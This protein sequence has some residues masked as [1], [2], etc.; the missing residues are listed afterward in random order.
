MGHRHYLATCGETS[1]WKH[2]WREVFLSIKTFELFVRVCVCLS[3]CELTLTLW[4]LCASVSLC[5]CVCRGHVYKESSTRCHTQIY[6]RRFDRNNSDLPRL[7]GSMSACHRASSSHPS[8][9]NSYF[10]LICIFFTVAKSF[11][12][13]YS[14]SNLNIYV[15]GQ[16]WRFTLEFYTEWW[17][18]SHRGINCSL[19]GEINIYFSMRRWR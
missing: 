2:W 16:L 12:R 13:G 3:L 5:I 4:L 15:Q 6:E 10:T 14:S 7:P 18:R 8:S 11:I 1:L 17:R 19:G 9:L